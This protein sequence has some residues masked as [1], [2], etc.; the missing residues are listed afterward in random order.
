MEHQVGLGPKRCDQLLHPLHG[1]RFAAAKA[2]TPR[3]QEEFGA[4]FLWFARELLPAY[5]AYDQK[6]VSQQPREDFEEVE[7]WTLGFLVDFCMEALGL[8]ALNDTFVGIYSALVHSFA[9]R[10]GDRPPEDIKTEWTIEKMTGFSWPRYACDHPCPIAVYELVR[11]LFSNRPEESITLDS[12]TVHE[13]LLAAYVPAVHDY[14]ASR[15]WS[16]SVRELAQEIAARQDDPRAVEAAKLFCT[17]LSGGWEAYVLGAAR[18][19][20]KTD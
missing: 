20:L 3:G 12:P 7:G 10:T 4:Q 16:P 17:S 2:K 1:H 15:F 5:L 6:V 9:E 13:Q 18:A 11:D 14:L 8:R 19:A